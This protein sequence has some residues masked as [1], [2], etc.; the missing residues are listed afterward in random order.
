MMKILPK[1]E[2]I[3]SPSRDEGCVIV[4]AHEN[5]GYIHFTKV[6]VSDLP[7]YLISIDDLERLRIDKINLTAITEAE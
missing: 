2:W 5:N 4:G 6:V 1:S 7:N 3:I